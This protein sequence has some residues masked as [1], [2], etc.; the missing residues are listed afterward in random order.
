M[1]TKSWRKRYLRAR[2]RMLDSKLNNL[3]GRGLLWMRNS[4]QKNLLDQGL[5]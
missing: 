5:Q 1:E 4:K 3:K 2:W